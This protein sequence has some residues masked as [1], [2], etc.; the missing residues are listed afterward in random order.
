MKINFRKN[1]KLI[2][3]LIS[4]LLIATASAA[5]YV[6][7][8]WTTTATVAANP[9]VCFVKWSDNSKQNTFDY[10][11]NIFPSIKTVDENITHGVW[12]WN[13]EAHATY[14]RWYSLTN[15]GNIAS[16]NVTVYNS[17]TTIYSQ[18]WSSVPSLPTGWV[19][20]NP[21]PMASGKYTIW[22]EIT[23]TSGASGSSV[24]TF[25]MKVE[26]P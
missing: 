17:T 16:L 5:A 19:Q 1:L 11:V 13:T 22:I 21:S 23:A 10:A 8:Q 7:L 18:Y 3:L 25:D 2:T 9:K 12:N 20:F 26:N 14:M 15:S 6:T 24:L 4:S